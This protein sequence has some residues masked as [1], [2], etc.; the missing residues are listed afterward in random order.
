MNDN[1]QRPRK[2]LVMWSGGL[3]STYGLV[4]L[5]RETSDEIFAHHIHRRARHDAGKHIA[6]TCEHEAEAIKRM[7]PYI[8]RTYRTFH[9]S[10]SKVDL[11]AFYRFARDTSTAMFFAS[12]AAKS[13]GFHAE[14]RILFSM[15][16]DEDKEWNTGSETYP[17]LRSVTISIMKLVWGSE[18]VPQ[19]FLWPE[20][21]AKQEETDYLPLEL[22]RMTASCRDPKRNEKKNWV[23]CGQCVEC[24]TLKDVKH[25]EAHPYRIHA[26][27]T[28]E[29]ESADKSSVAIEKEYVLHAQDAD[30]NKGYWLNV[31]EALMC[32]TKSEDALS[33]DNRLLLTGLIKKGWRIRRHLSGAVIEIA[34]P[35]INVAEKNKLQDGFQI[36]QN[37]FSEIAM[38]MAARTTTAV[39]EMMFRDSSNLDT[40]I[41]FLP[42]G[43]QTRDCAVIFPHPAARNFIKQ[44]VE[45][46]SSSIPDGLKAHEREL[47]FLFGGLCMTRIKINFGHKFMSPYKKFM[48]VSPEIARLFWHALHQ[49][50]FLQNEYNGKTRPSAA[51]ND[52]LR[53]EFLNWFDPLGRRM[54]EK[55]GMLC[56]SND[57]AAI[58][59]FRELF[60]T[61][62]LVDDLVRDFWH[63]SARP[64]VNDNGAYVV[65]LL[66]FDGCV[67]LDKLIEFAKKTSERIIE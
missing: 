9:Y 65:E 5:L 66:C 31:E 11:T 24:R 27:S 23:F 50:A 2:T 51:S 4:R 42:S 67:P 55:A 17:F 64:K 35:D 34:S 53:E 37:V 19:C 46:R 32:L 56:S 28:S 25:V 40:K 49:A 13:F 30:G 62:G 8:I 48:P 60:G 1:S 15:N 45:K 57:E 59:G 10:D 6:L 38:K 44:I 43:Q 33:A 18:E 12:Q 52:S 3:D 14:D 20:P 22:V 7:L 16:S 47:S 26:I 61:G 36:F 41:F 29:R 39:K 21:P 58:T 63:L 54:I